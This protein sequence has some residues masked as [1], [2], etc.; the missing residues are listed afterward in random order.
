[1]SLRSPSRAALALLTLAVL[2][3]AATGAAGAAPLRQTPEPTSTQF[4]RPVL[5]LTSYSVNGTVKPGSKF[6]LN[7]RVANQGGAKARNIVFTVVPG[8]FLPSGSGGVISG[9]AISSGADTGYSQKLV[10][11]GEVALK[12]YGT[13]QITAA[14]TDD[15][16]TSYSET[17]NLTLSVSHPSSS[18]SVRPTS[19]PTPSPRPI[20][21]IGGY[22]V[23]LDPLRPGSVFNL[24]VQVSNVGGTE[25]RSVTLVI[26][27]GTV[28][29][30]DNGTPGAPS[31][32][33]SATGGLENFAPLGESNV[34]YLGNLGP[35]AQ[36]T[37]IH[38]LIV[39]S[40]TTPG[41]YPLKISLIYNDSGGRTYTDDQTIT[42]LVYSP[43]ML[44][45][46]FYQP[47]DP[48]FVGQPGTLPIQVL[49]LDRKPVTL[50][51]VR[52]ES[53]GAEI[54]NGQLPIGYLDTGLAFTI[55]SQAAAFAPGPLDVVVS[56]DYIDDFNEAQVI[57]QTLTVD[58]M[59]AA[60]IPPDAGE[61]GGGIAEPVVAQ[62]ET[63]WT[64][65]L[66]FLRG[67]LGLD[68]APPQTIP[69]QG[70]PTE[71]PIQIKPGAPGMKG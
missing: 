34:A 44:E 65:V 32:G 3:L 17:Y 67:L 50:S 26:G 25:A 7:F 14:Y 68:S 71:A 16:G 43:P 13:L 12:A 35:G 70:V 18:G 27:G 55:D 57:Q 2:S 58:V 29:T 66:R 69:P 47:P 38:A 62:P 9:G 33:V 40:T 41:A 49:N 28:S 20:L 8:D 54:S 22:H 48:L 53:A 4:Q 36:L 61:G 21:L 1:M 63:L 59:E 31:G 60:P 39:N 46:S 6:T 10:A 11:S 15:F 19:T 52:V 23:D 64:R 5:T 51:R 42:L 56:V 45:I 30:N 37:S 24:E